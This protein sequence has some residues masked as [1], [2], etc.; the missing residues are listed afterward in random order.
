ETRGRVKW[1]TGFGKSHRLPERVNA[2]SRKFVADLAHD[3]VKQDVDEVYSAVRET[4]GYKRRDVEGSSDRGTGFVRTPDFEYSVSVDQAADDPT[5]VV[6][7]RELAGIRTPEGVLDRP[8]Q[9]GFGG[10]FA[11][12]GFQLRQAVH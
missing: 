1:L 3:D 5:S 6:W 12:P 11:T 2:G 8:F 9:A 10:V 7:R 4:M